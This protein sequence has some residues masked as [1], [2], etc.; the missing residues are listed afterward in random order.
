MKHLRLMQFLVFAIFASVPSLSVCAQCGGTA[1]AANSGAKLVYA[2]FQNPVNGRPVSAN[3]G[4]TRLNRYSQNMGVQPKVRGLENVDPPVPALARVT[5][6]DV[7]AAF[8]Y[9]LRMPNDWAGVSMEVVGHPEKDGKLI[10]DDISAYKFISIRLFAKG[11][12]SVRVELITRGQGFN[13]DGGYPFATIRLSPGFNTYRFKLDTF[14]QPDWATRLDFKH[15]VLKKLTS[16]A[17]GVFCEQCRTE[18]GTVVV[19]NIAFEK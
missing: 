14:T 9:E 5:D 2:D 12:Q 18:S 17:V 19:D 4:P 13:L 11:P 3:G 1:K 16:V 8:E 15:D 10:A 7:A 6:A